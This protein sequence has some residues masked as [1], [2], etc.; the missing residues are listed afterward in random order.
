MAASKIEW[1]LDNVEGARERA[2]KGEL[3]FGTVDTWI[4]WKLT[5]GKAHVTDGTNASRTMLFNINTMEWDDE[6]LKLFRIPRCM[7]PKVKKSG[8]IFGYANLGGEAVPIAGIAGDQQAA[9]FGQG[10]FESGEGKN[11]Y[12]TGCFLLMNAGEERP[13]SKNGLLTTVAATL[14]GQKTQY[15]LEGSVFIG[16]AVIQW[17]RDEMRFFSESSSMITPMA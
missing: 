11:T 17:L 13:T 7:L 2:E 14:N 15:A 5:N 10:C 12:G 6:L 4:V 9:L 3:L 16:G 1:I 8:E